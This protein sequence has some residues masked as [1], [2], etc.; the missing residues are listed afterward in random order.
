MIDIQYYF[1][2]F[3]IFVSWSPVNALSHPAELKR[4][5]CD[6][7]FFFAL[8]CFFWDFVCLL[9]FFFSFFFFFKLLPTFRRCTDGQSYKAEAGILKAHI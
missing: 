3:L 5:D 6:R 7:S 8:L 4:E 9:L 2:E 1:Q